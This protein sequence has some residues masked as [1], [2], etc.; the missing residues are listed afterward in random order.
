VCDGVNDA[1]EPVFGA[2][3]EVVGCAVVASAVAVAV[4]VGFV[5]FWFC[6]GWRFVELLDV[7]SAA[8]VG[9]AVVGSAAAYWLR[10]RMGT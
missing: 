4:L 5:W 8:V 9:G 10:Q 6:S 1:F 7:L 2:A 3:F